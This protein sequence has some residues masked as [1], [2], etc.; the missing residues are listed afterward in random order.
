MNPS[1]YN[2]LTIFPFFFVDTQWPLSLDLDPKATES[3]MN[4]SFDLLPPRINTQTSISKI[5][6]RQN[7]LEEIDELHERDLLMFLP[8]KNEGIN[9]ILVLGHFCKFN[10]SKDDPAENNPS[11]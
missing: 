7:E 3:K 9:E 1:F 4:C 5:N 8:N 11:P 2:F 6:H 10:S